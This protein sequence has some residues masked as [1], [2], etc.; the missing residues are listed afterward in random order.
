MKRF[1]PTV[2]LAQKILRRYVGEPFAIFLFS[3]LGNKKFAPA[4]VIQ[5]TYYE[6]GLRKSMTDPENNLVEYTYDKA[7][8]LA[9]AKRNTV[10]ES[11]YEY[12]ALGLRTKLTYGNTSY[13][14]YEYNHSLRWLTKLS[15]KKSDASVISSFAY[16]HDKVGNRKTMTLA[17]GDAIT[18]TYDE[19]YQLTSE[20]RTGTS[21][22]NISWTYDEV[23]NRLTQLKDSVQTTYTYNDAN[24]LLSDTTSGV[25]TTYEYDNNG[26][27]I[28]KTKGTDIWQWAYDYENRQVSYDDPVNTNDAACTYDASG[29]RIIKNVNA[30]VEKHIL[31]GANVILDLDGSNNVSAT[32][33]TP[34]LDQNLLVTK[35]S[36]TYYYL[37]D[38]L[39][40][41]RNVVDST[42]TTQ[43]SYDYYAFGETLS[44]TENISNRYKY[45]SRE[46]DN[47]SSYFYY[48]ARYYLPTIGRFSQRDPLANDIYSYI[49]GDSATLI[50]Y[51]EYID[52][53]NF[54]I[55]VRNNPG[56]LT[57][58]SGMKCCCE[59]GVC[60]SDKEGEKCRS[61]SVCFIVGDVTTTFGIDLSGWAETLFADELP[62]F[63]KACCNASVYRH[64]TKASFCDL[65]K[66]CDS[67]VFIGHTE[68]L[69][70]ESKSAKITGIWLDEN[71]MITI[72]DAKKCWVNRRYDYVEIGSCYSMAF[73][74][75]I[76]T[77][78]FKGT[79]RNFSPTR[80]L[81]HLAVFGLDPDDFECCKVIE[82]K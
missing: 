65:M 51:Y 77:K 61:A 62:K 32:Y 17:N 53:R 28:K 16:T 80:Y 63:T 50:G 7:K 79:G 68:G 9:T 39:G 47:E 82:K 20:I 4:K 27:Q 29:S 72:E 10:T 69:V 35:N 33:I 22:Y 37:Q 43:N 57:D 67:W 18:Y 5:Y 25:T 70:T 78:T 11:T 73:E 2:S 48:R 66:E 75:L 34:F 30:V 6:D 71:T 38:G 58:P 24:Q 54:Y 14:E 60:K 44:E 8:R 55:Y 1:D 59:K 76:S 15:N 31:D 46:W 81:V 49:Y 23:G 74:T 13:A 41:T 52:G 42:Q 19:I 56:N 26:N 21:A 40:S 64:P 3:E 36:N 12:N 45:T